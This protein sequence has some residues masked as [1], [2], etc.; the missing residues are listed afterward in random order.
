MIT[1]EINEWIRNVECGMYSEQDAM[2]RFSKFAK[3]LTKSELIQIQKKL[4]NFINL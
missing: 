1:K 3:F 2:Y 4:K